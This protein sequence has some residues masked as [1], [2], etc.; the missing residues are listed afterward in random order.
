[1]MRALLRPLSPPVAF[2]PARTETNIVLTR[3]ARLSRTL[4]TWI[5]IFA[6]VPLLVQLIASHAPARAADGQFVSVAGGHLVYGGQPI[7][8]KGV[9]FYPRNQAWAHMWMYWDG[10]A[11]RADLSPLPQFGANTVRILLPYREDQAIIDATGAVRPVILDR[12]RQAVHMAGDL[13][14]KVIITL[15]DWYDDTPAATDPRWEQNRA[16]LRSLAAA[17]GGDD[18][19]LGWELHNEPDLYDSWS[20]RPAAAIDWLLRVSAELHQLAPR[21]LVTVGVAHAAALWQA[22][23]QGRTLLDGSDF[24]SFHSYDGGAIDAEIAGIRAHTTKPVVLEETGW[25]TGPCGADPNYSEAHQVDLYRAMLGAAERENLDGVLA[26][27]LWDLPPTSSSGSGVESEQDHF[28]LLRLDGTLKPGAQLFQSGFQTDV[29]PL[30]SASAGAVPL[31]IAPTP[32]PVTHP[33]NWQPPLVFPETG[34]DVWDEFRDYWRRFGGLV[35]FGYPITQARMEGDLKVQYFERAR[36]E[37]HPTNARLP[38]YK[39]L[40]KAGQLRLLVQLTLLGAP[41]AAGHNWPPAAPP[42]GSDAR[43]FPET[44]HTLR[45]GFRAYWEQNNG[46]TN[47]GYP[48]SEELSEVSAED[49]KTYTVQYFER[50]RFE[51]HPENAGT[52]YVVL[53]GHLGTEMLAARGCR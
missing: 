11:T 39:N 13:R 24:V 41:L 2:S 53:L 52:P 29:S 32:G 46:L 40:D 38:G 25:P 16:Y 14:L 22:D 48:L 26:W 44:Q 1:M 49:G 9:S 37:L 7:R 15:F 34:H 20:T 33:P 35:V 23:P 12:L 5:A 47:F 27:M 18:R 17:F 30:G 36:F 43:W 6:L 45:G 3:P 10:P 31:T 8:L 50:A 51:Y 42:T 19:V 28:G 4:P 21:Q